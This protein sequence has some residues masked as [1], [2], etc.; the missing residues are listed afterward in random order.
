MARTLLP[1]GKVDRTGL[2]RWFTARYGYRPGWYTVSEAIR[3]GLPCEPHPLSGKPIFTIKDVEAW[4]EARRKSA[5]TLGS[6]R[7]VLLPK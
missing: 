3:Q 2:L 7:A 5:V 1:T 4:I 6:Q